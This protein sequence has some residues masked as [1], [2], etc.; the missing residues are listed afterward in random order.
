MTGYKRAALSAFRVLRP[1]TDE[2]RMASWL[3]DRLA[4]HGVSASRQTIYNWLAGTVTI[5]HKAWVALGEVENDA[6]AHLIGQLEG[7]GK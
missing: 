7:L 1:C 3:R 6:K 4:G 5:P 2:S